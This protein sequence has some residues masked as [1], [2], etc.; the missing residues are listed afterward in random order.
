MVAVKICGVTTPADADAVV[1]A[2]ADAIGLNFY[3]ASSRYLTIDAASAIVDAIDGRVLT[4]G[5]FVDMP[6]ASVE[7]VRE[8]TGIVCVQLHGD[9]SPQELA[10]LL[11]HAYKALRVR[12]PEVLLDVGRFGGDHVLLDAYVAGQPGGTGEAFDW[13]LA[14]ELARTRKL[15]LA[16]G[17]TPENVAEA[18]KTVRPFCVD[19]AGGVESAPGVKD[20]EL[21]EAFIENA[22]AADS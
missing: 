5:V 9:E 16:G 13:D 15:T 17:L 11:P 2:G 3:P 10:L 20:M 1:L 21:V 7:R 4:V 8:Q 22:R 6:V 14:T 18:V 12:G 19:T